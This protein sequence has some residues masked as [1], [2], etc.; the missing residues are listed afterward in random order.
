MSG[1]G[2]EPDV[3]TLKKIYNNEWCLS[4]QSMVE[5]VHSYLLCLHT[6]TN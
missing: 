5:D 1:D 6:Q 2:A 4:E 3:S